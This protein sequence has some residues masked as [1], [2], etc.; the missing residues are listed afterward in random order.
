MSL[1]PLVFTARR[2]AAVASVA[3][4]ALLFPMM[5]TSPAAAA[6]PGSDKPTPISEVRQGLIQLGGALAAS[7]EQPALSDDLPLT[8]TSV[9]DL[10][11]LDTAIGSIVTDK[12]SAKGDTTLDTL[13][14]AF[15]E[16]GPIE[17]K[18]AVTS[19]GAPAKSREWTMKVSLRKAR[20]VALTYKTDQIEFGTAKLG[21]QLA[22]SLDATIRFRYVDD[23]SVPA[24]RRFAVVGD[25]TLTTHLWS[26]NAGTDE[27]ADEVQIPAFKAVD[28]FVQL[29]ATGKATIDS[30][31]VLKLRDPNGRGQITT[32]DLRF[33]EATDMFV[34][35]GLPARDAVSM[36]IDL[37]TPISDQATG[38]L[39]VGP[40]TDDTTT[41]P[42]VGAPKR[43]AAMRDLTSVTRLQALTGFTQYTGAVQTLEAEVDQS[44]P[45]LDR[46]LSDLFSPGA[47]LVG[48]LT[49]QATATIVCGAA[50]TLPPSGA[51][52]PGEA[53]YCQA[54]TTNLDAKSKETIDWSS[55]DG[56]VDF[57]T[58]TAGT[59]GRKPT[60]NV[61]VTK[62]DGFPT[63]IVDFTGDDG[64]SRTARS[65]I[66]SIQ[67]LGQAVDDLGLGGAVTFDPDKK[68]LQIA[69]EQKG[70]P[71]GDGVKVS[72]GGNGNLAPM[73]GLAGLC[74][75]AQGAADEPRE[76]VPTGDQKNGK[77]TPQSGEAVVATKGRLFDAAF[78]IG[79]PPEATPVA[80]QP[81]PTEPTFYLKPGD[82]GLVYQVDKATASLPKN[83]R[84]VA[85]IGFL[86]ADVDV[87]DY[88][89]EQSGKAASLTVPT[90][91][92]PLPS[93]ETVSGA[94]TLK[95][96]L[97]DSSA[98]AKGI[99][100]ERGL[101]AK[102]TL[103]VQASYQTKGKRPFD[104]KG[105][106]QAGWSKL[107]PDR[108]PSITATAGYDKLRLLDVVP[109]R[110][111]VMTAGSADGTIKDST[112]D[113]EKQ[114][115]VTGTSTDDR[116]VLRSLY[117]L[118]VE[119]SSSTICTTFVVVGPHEL[120]CT[121]G[122]LA[123]RGV[124]GEGHPYLIEGDQDA[125]RDIVIE[126]LATVLNAFEAPDP[127]LNANRSFPLVDL[128]PSEIS[129]ARNSLGE[130][131]RQI[132]AKIEPPAP[133]DGSAT[134][135][136]VDVSSMQS[137]SREFSAL[138]A[139]A[140]KGEGNVAVGTP[141]LDFRL[142]TADGGRLVLESSLGAKGSRKP[143]LRFADGPSQVTV[144]G[145]KKDDVEDPVTLPVAVESS[146]TVV[147][148]VNLTDVS[149]VVR[150]DTATKEVI[151]NVE[152]NGDD[153]ETRLADKPTDYGSARVT[154]GAKADIKVGIGVQA[155]TSPRGSTGTWMPLD[156]L[157]SQMQQTRS[158]PQ[159]ASAQN[160]SLTKTVPR[161]SEI[162]ACIKL[163]IVSDPATSTVEVAL[164]ADETSNGTGGSMKAQPI[165]YRFLAEGLNGLSQTLTDAL[166]GDQV[167][168][169][170]NGKQ[171]PTGTVPLSLPL[172]GTNLDAGADVPGDVK[173]FVSTVRSAMQ[174]VETAMKPAD[175]KEKTVADLTSELGKALTGVSDKRVTIVSA[176]PAITCTE[177]CKDADPV[178]TVTDVEVKLALAG[179]AADAVDV[180]FQVGPSGA[181]IVTTSTV[182]AKAMWTLD[183]TVG[184]TRGAGAY[185]R[186]PAVV[187][188]K[189]MLTVDVDATLDTY[190]KSGVP[191][192]TCHSWRRAKTWLDSVNKPSKVV[193]DDAI[194]S[195]PGNGSR[196]VDAYVGK[197]PSVLVDQKQA[198]GKSTYV[199]AKIAVDFVAPADAQDGKV[200]VPALYDGK[201]KATTT[202]TGAG[203]VSAYFE[204]FAGEAGFFDVVGT[205]LLNWD[206]TYGSLDY[207]RLKL[208]VGT[209]RDAVLPGF[210]KALAWLAPLNPAVDQLT[211]PIPVVTELGKLS[212]S[213]DETTMLSL[214]QGGK[215]PIN[216]IL[217]LLQLQNVVVPKDPKSSD[218]DLRDIAA[219]DIGGFK[220]APSK[221]ELGGCT[222]TGT[223]D[224]KEYKRETGGKGDSGRC[225]RSTLDKLGK[226]KL[227]KDAP[228][229]KIDKTSVNTPYFSLP[230][231]SL[232]V[233]QDT[234]QIMK[235]L[236][237]TGDAT[238]LYVDL[239]HAGLKKKVQRTF[240]PFV[241]GVIPATVVVGGEVGFDGRFAFGFDTRG[242]SRKIDS[243]STGD[244]GEFE[245]VLAG[246]TKPKLFSDG[247]YINDLEDGVDVPEIKLTFTITAGVAVTVGIVSVGLNGG[248]TLDLSLN[249]FDP[250]GDGKIYTDEFAGSSRGPACA[251]DVSSG[252]SFSLSFF[253]LIDFLFYTL[254]EDFTL[255][256]S[257]RLKI[258]DFNCEVKTPV[259][260]TEQTVSRT[261]AQ[262]KAVTQ[263]ALVLTMGS[264]SSKREAFT[265]IDE[266][267]TV[268]QVG[269][270]KGGK[271][272]L[273]VS[274]FNLVQNYE[275]D[276]GTVVVADGGSGSD[277]IRAFAIPTVTTNAKGEPEML[278]PGDAGYPVFD[279][280]VYATGGGAADTI[281]T[282]DGDDVV[283][284]DD[285]DDTINS[286][287]GNDV[288]TGGTGNDLLNGGLGHDRL[289]GGDDDDKV[290]GGPGADEV[291]GEAGKDVVDGGVGADRDGQFPNVS[292]DAIRPTLD[293]GDLV[294]GGDGADKVTGGDGSDVVVGGAYSAD[295]ATFDTSASTSVVGVSS[296]KE[297]LDVDVDDIKTVVLPSADQI[298]TQCADPGA[299]GEVGPDN[300]TGG[301]DGDV[302]IGGAGGDLLSGGAGADR[303]CG[304]A[305]DDLLRGDDTDVDVKLQ[306]PDVVRG[307][308]GVDR[309]Y[310]AGGADDLKGDDG[311]DLVRGG[312]GDDVIAGGGGSDLLVGE[313]GIDTVDG[314]N[315]AGSAEVD[316]MPADDTAS[317]RSMVCDVSTSIVGGRIDLDGD[318]AGNDDGLLEGMVVRDGAVLDAGGAP[319]EGAIDGIVFKDG[320]IDLNGN[321]TVQPRT[322]DAL[323]DTGPVDLAGITLAAG[324]GDCI[325]G[326]DEVDTRLSGGA[327]ADYIDAGAGNDTNVRGGSGNDLVRGGLGNDTLHG[328]SGDDLVAGD[329]G[330]DILFGNADDDVLRGGG[331]ND[332]LAGGGS[333][334]GDPDGSDEV[335]G[336]GDDDVVVGGN[337]IL[338]RTPIDKTA[339]AGVG[340]TLLG[341]PLTTGRDDLAYGGVGNDFVFGQNGRDETYGGP[342]DDVVEGGSEV[343]LVQGDDG[344]DLLVGGSSTTGA[345]TTDRSAEGVADGGD[346]VI[347]DGGVDGKP[348][349]DV[350]VGD[351][352]RLRVTTGTRSRWRGV[353]DEVAVDLFDVPVTDGPAPAAESS[354]GDTMSAGA[355]DDL[356]FGQGG[357]D[358]ITAGDGADA[359]E[360]GSGRDTVSGGADDDKIV[361]GSWTAKT[362]DTGDV[363][364]GDGG[365]DEIL[366]DNGNPTDG[367]SL[368]V[369]L[370]DA[371]APGR[372]PAEGTSGGDTIAGGGGF[373][374]I[375]GQSGQDAL[376]GDDGVDV[377]EGG[378]DVDTID[379]GAGDDILTGGSSSKDGVISPS[380]DGS[381]Q[382]DGRDVMTG[383]SGDDVLAGDNARI[384]LTGL[385][386]IDGTPMRSVLLF[387][388]ATASKGAAAGTGGSDSID[389][390]DGRDLVFGQAGDDAL[391][392]GGDTDYLEGNDGAD[393]LTG[394][395]GEDDLV[396]GGSSR[397]GAVI[398]VD[399]GSVVD[400]LLT[401]PGGTT[402][403]SASGLVDGN[404]VL[405]GG[406]AR[407]VLLGDN[408]RIT[409]GGPVALLGGGASGPHAVRKVAMADKV[410]GVWAGSDRLAGGQGDDDLYG[411]FDSTRTKRPGQ[412][413]AG[414]VVPGD[415]LVGGVGDD[416]I[417]G[418]QGV[419]VPTQAAALGAVS[420]TVKD[421]KSFVRE[422][423]RPRGSLV[424]VVTLTHARQGGD[425]LVIGDDGAD[426]VHAGAGKDVVNAGGGK[427]VV[428]GGDG[429]DAL[430]GG[431]DHDRVFG[432]EG[433]DLLDV[434]RR[435]SHTPLWKVAA[436]SAD[437]DGR[438]RTTNGGDLLFGGSGADGLQ[439]DEGDVAGGKRVQGD[440]LIDWRA[441]VNVFKTCRTGRGTGKVMDESSASTIK[442]L[443][444]I[445]KASG[446]VGS[447]EIAIPFNERV[448]RY[449][450][451]PGFVCER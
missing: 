123:D 23:S 237:D 106:I 114:F 206:G 65:A 145:N 303:V 66:S 202:A 108:L 13:A 38:T 78:G 221:I 126:D 438:R 336:D 408:G 139:K 82:D 279:T 252:I 46:S 95:D 245:K 147:L 352:A 281:D 302:V 393:S 451:R 183:A 222:E 178:S 50:D 354:G 197:F 249:A 75:A 449:P 383:G 244:I 437:T 409:R 339:I 204:S 254:Y 146:A 127:S 265:D 285:G 111:A 25:S 35:T 404:D 133:V 140:V 239:G 121:K 405:D 214:L 70:T 398:T 406:D 148:G 422:L 180:P 210:E 170:A 246:G 428:F 17:I 169:D 431:G 71:D 296:T 384:D 195:A 335:L 392:G 219:N 271:V 242:L 362:A 380:R 395:S 155:V 440:R 364:M 372:A 329:R 187:A 150:A 90:S 89:V 419:D 423:V 349:S 191:D 412:T 266:K 275:V 189:P 156:S 22:G 304:R 229:T 205:V 192:A 137:F 48:L 253:V 176:T 223:V 18:D 315:T 124:V 200:Y 85:R 337:A 9:R 308:P 371:P 72:T 218:P 330:D 350:L 268:R 174:G 154:S 286:G 334:A 52:Q 441:K 414:A 60:N 120:T 207:G 274:A 387:D 297:L 448:T 57:S 129:V 287:T 278:T 51:P 365:D 232:P 288:V 16:G 390:E 175:D 355:E 318:L 76:C 203:R 208:D 255:L 151:K 86:Q 2:T 427:D 345:V 397:T 58:D 373:D 378:A 122:P 272:L 374:R 295:R 160:C 47:Q 388:L 143:A 236:Q 407:D 45:L 21:D 132:R 97:T 256:K 317:A 396:G 357:D 184:V 340:V 161:A 33:S 15:P 257:P 328:D 290:S 211:K 426:S 270:P 299:P 196:C 298:A 267:Y 34:T 348:G 24:L 69:V 213:S 233:L 434:K 320:L 215:T 343:D 226:G 92:V 410:P 375:F 84:M 130:A 231:V 64:A 391:G 54:I 346:Q 429:N 165:A 224:G 333:T 80:G 11:S 416:A 159:D 269:Q 447:S 73:T 26:S 261:D 220:V 6:D 369:S 240:G 177:T 289:L 401:A 442:A 88:S 341:T 4:F 264:E 31:T 353:R 188:N 164:R 181:T 225:K 49:Q 385:T 228:G 241:L 450:G 163:P 444:E 53:R 212:G 282:S 361:G 77:V 37:S 400:R 131:I 433:N 293:S 107:V 91:D 98:A 238:M 351:N 386:R 41:Y 258:F 168:L 172:V 119:G 319:F 56:A 7:A 379:G 8:D 67:D 234:S 420:R 305:G 68:S 3:S 12:L 359:V 116:T 243:L 43:S 313:A 446:A 55:P 324:N 283:D 368:F 230:S 186:L 321:G 323:G 105:T 332:L 284:G 370:L 310:G 149:S 417:V 118:G 277:T 96:L 125:L 27:G 445:A 102:A 247:F 260:A 93:K 152:R 424:R 312:V 263:K 413:Y 402:D 63:L 40:R 209:L 10:L 322:A 262:G 179:K 1:R 199:D 201:V 185:L 227:D 136:P 251:F 62:G 59:V 430:W 248:V 128:V 436:P 61:T 316:P 311:D 29:D 81:V 115:G 415:V 377:L 403:V 360:G 158:I 342:G 198:D 166:D 325:L 366:G 411:Q 389:G 193:D 39:T 87:T 338:S 291:R 306:G 399:G 30:T 394:G 250:N 144:V 28:G 5:G 103:D 363:L 356:V 301:G 110:Q 439:A 376:D 94:V 167:L 194:D 173:K 162:A 109:S 294:V 113:F 42:V 134:P 381:G 382:L 104:D 79:L 138:L 309:I 259:L 425:D 36:A 421:K 135:D 171:S 347:G 358:V 182:P 14:E 217:N 44:F 326:G 100:A 32:E 19:P 74:Q 83:A 216:V 20:S 112:A 432:G 190:K 99:K 292:A 101:S 117:D 273:Q 153:V 300:V 157:R 142:E 435:A 418:D 331:G 443:R 367:T 314:D 141:T 280:P 344:D 276:E 327:G 235:L 307:G